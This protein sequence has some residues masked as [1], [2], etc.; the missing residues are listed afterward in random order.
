MKT[1][2][3]TVLLTATA[4]APAYAEEHDW[5]GGGNRAAPVAQ[6]RATAPPAPVAPVAHNNGPNGG[7]AWHGYAGG[8][9][10]APQLQQVPP[11]QN[12]WNRGFAG[13]QAPQRAFA[14]PVNQ[15]PQAFRAG[16]PG[17]VYGQQP[18]ARNDQQFNRGGDRG[19]W[20]QGGDH[21][22]WNRGGDNR[23]WHGDDHDHGRWNRDWRR[24]ARYN[25]QSYR[26]Y[27]RDFFHVG[28]YYNPYGYG[29]GYQ[30][31]GVGFF[32]DAPFYSNDYWIN[33]PYDY[34]LPEAYGDTRWIR[35]YNDVVLVD[36][37]T[38]EVLDVIH[39]FFW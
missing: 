24:D 36:I 20:A 19:Q 25:W 17:Q 21:G 3:I 34:R 1:V 2:L 31:F 7:Y 39:N 22:Q 29:F 38:G 26:D 28:A 9:Q 5:H 6:P 32:I 27:N 15:A 30:T 4:I 14:P 11:A 23:G 16:Q 8:A 10:R 35:Y 18:L 33:D 12:N 37:D 13:G